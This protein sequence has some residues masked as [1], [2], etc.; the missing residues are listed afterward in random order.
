MVEL[1]AFF[2]QRLGNPI[3]NHDPAHGK[4]AGSQTFG[5]GHE[6]G[7]E[8]VVVRAKPTAGATEAADYLVDNQQDVVFLADT[9]NLGPIAFG[10][11][12]DTPGPLDRLTDERTDAIGANL[13]NTLFK[14]A[15]Y[16]MLEVRVGVH[17]IPA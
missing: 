10:W 8:T 7:L 11:D 13:P 16:A 5:D 2:D 14:R 9:G 15:F 6:V 1:A 17:D 12:D 4:I 3:P